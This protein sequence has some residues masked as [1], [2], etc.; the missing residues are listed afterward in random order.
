MGFILLSDGS[1]GAAQPLAGAIDGVSSVAAA[2]AVAKPLSATAAS[3]ESVVTATT[4]YPRVARA[5]FPSSVTGTCVVTAIIGGIPRALASTNAGTR[6]NGVCTVTARLN[7][8]PV[9]LRSTNAGTRPNGVCTVS[10]AL[11]APPALSGSCTG[12]CTVS[13]SLPIF[14]PLQGTSFG[15]TTAAGSI[16]IGR[17]LASTTPGLTTVIGAL[18]N[19]S[20][21]GTGTVTVTGTST[22]SATLGKIFSRTATSNLSILAH[23]QELLGILM[24][25]DPTFQTELGTPPTAQTFAFVKKVVKGL[26]YV[27]IQAAGS[28]LTCQVKTGDGLNHSAVVDVAVRTIGSGVIGVGTGTAL[29]GVGTN[30]VWLQ[31][32]SAGAFSVVITGSGSVLVECFPKQGVVMSAGLTI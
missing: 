32:T 29:A 21:L 6:P 18:S 7:Y 12:T 8:A 10:A 1:S 30:A 14:R 11:L 22:V 9:I 16:H 15:S 19:S 4:T 3:S 23:Y 20:G 28:T 5:L 26:F 2:L 25:V 13:G 24:L 17:A 31:T 27:D